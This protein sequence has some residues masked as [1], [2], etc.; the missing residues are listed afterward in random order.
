MNRTTHVF[1]VSLG[2][3][4]SPK[5][6]DKI[7]QLYTALQEGSAVLICGPSGSG[8]SVLY[9]TLSLVLNKLHIRRDD[10]SGADNIRPSKPLSVLQKNIPKV[11]FSSQYIQLLCQATL[12]ALLI[13]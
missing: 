1:I 6:M 2:L 4:H 8:K 7:L 12:H 13:L 11:C 3:Q 10:S 5:L 9:K